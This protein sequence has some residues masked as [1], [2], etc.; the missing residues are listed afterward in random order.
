MPDNS[1][2]TNVCKDSDLPDHKTKEIAVVDVDVPDSQQFSRESN[3]KTD[4]KK[5]EESSR[6]A[7]ISLL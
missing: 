3:S 5:D 4:D 7:Y 6:K 1:E 2:E